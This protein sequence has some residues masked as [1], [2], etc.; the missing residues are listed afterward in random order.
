[1]L[2]LILHHLA[3]YPL[4]CQIEFSCVYVNIGFSSIP[5]NDNRLALP[6]LQYTKR[7]RMLD[8]P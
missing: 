2:E 1:M 3:P 6:C 8:K 4:C 7:N 5:Q